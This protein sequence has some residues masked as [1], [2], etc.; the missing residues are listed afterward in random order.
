MKSHGTKKRKQRKQADLGYVHARKLIGRSLLLLGLRPLGQPHP[1]FR[2]AVDA[3]LPNGQRLHFP[4]GKVVEQQV[5]E[6]PVL[7]VWARLKWQEGSA[8]SY[9][10]LLLAQ[11]IDWQRAKRRRA[12]R[13]KGSSPLASGIHTL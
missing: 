2:C 6:T 10:K 11:T 9:Y 13:K 8:H 4:A 3:R 5:Q 7:P 12:K 1:Y